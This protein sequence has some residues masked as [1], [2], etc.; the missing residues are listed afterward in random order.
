[1]RPLALVVAIA[2]AGCGIFTVRAAD[3]VRS[4]AYEDLGCGDVVV[5]TASGGAYQA[6][7]C[8]QTRRYVCDREVATAATKP[9]ALAAVG[10]R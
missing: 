6:T 10:C 5:T 4:H 3:V 1:M 9:G 7:G 8:G 2:P